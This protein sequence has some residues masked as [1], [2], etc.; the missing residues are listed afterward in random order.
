VKLKIFLITAFVMVCA[1]QVHVSLI[2]KINEVQILISDDGRDSQVLRVALLSDLHVD[3]DESS[4]QDLEKLWLEVLA[5]QPDI[6]MLAGDYIN[7]G[8]KKRDI[9]QQRTRIAKILG[10]SDD[11]PVIAV[12]GNHD[13]WSNPALWS[14]DFRAAGIVVL[15]NQ[16]MEIDHLNVCIR[17]FGDAFTRNFRYLDFPASCDGKL[18]LSITHDPAGAFHPQVGGLILAGHTHCG[19][20]ALPLLGPIYVPSDA[21]KKSLCGLYE[22]SQRQVFVSSGIGTSILPIRFFTQSQWDLLTIS[23]P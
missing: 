20:I 3:D 16:V 9:A 4:F 19:Q 11:I 23:S 2:T 21:P 17:G 22:D 10:R 18:Q 7:D 6:I 14:L 12:L 8:R 15:E 5:E 13:E 1:Y